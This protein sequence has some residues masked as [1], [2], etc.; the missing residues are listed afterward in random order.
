LEQ[1]RAGPVGL[2]RNP[3]HREGLG[4]LTEG[5]EDGG[6]EEHEKELIEDEA[7]STEDEL[8]KRFG[9]MTYVIA[10][11]KLEQLSHGVE[12]AEAF[13]GD[14]DCPFLKRAWI[15]DPDDP[16]VE[17]YTQSLAHLREVRRRASTSI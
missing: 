2:F 1:G 14:S 12:V 7:D 13:H 6:N 15:T 16:R 3:E 11:N 17:K 4:I 10:T 8:K 9:R 5:N